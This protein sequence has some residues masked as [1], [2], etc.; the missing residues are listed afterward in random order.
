MIKEQKSFQNK[1]ELVNIENLV[2]KDH[3]LRKIDKYIDFSFISDLTKDLYCH[4]NGRPAV[5]PVVLFK[6]LFIGYLFGIRS[7]RQLVKEIEVNLAYRWF[8]GYSITDKI[9]S[10][11]TISQNRITRF[12]DTNIHQ[13]IFDNIVFQAIDK[14]LVDGKILYTDSTHLKADANKN[15]FTKEIVVQ[16]TKDYFEELEKDINDDRVAH[17]K[18]PLKKKRKNR[19][20]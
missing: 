9:P 8:L 14:K 4:D 19:G 1:L 7:E 10:H 3:L 12:K 11:S 13:E 20:N 17:G 15:K 2:P 18:Q 5:D 16:S 6:M